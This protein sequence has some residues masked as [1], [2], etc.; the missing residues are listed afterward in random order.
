F[1]ISG[2]NAHVI[3]EQFV[4]E[5]G[6]ASEAAIDLPVVPWVLSGKSAEA[7]R[8]QAARLLRYL[9]QTSDERAVDVGF[10]L[11]TSRSV[12]EHRAVVTGHDEGELLAGLTALVHGDAG[13]GV[14]VGSVR[15]GKTAFLFTGQGAQRVGMGR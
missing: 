13:R 7:L 5:E 15:T 1:G 12:L 10:S 9:G 8:G 6:V 11:A 2:T 4:E 3:V 14:V